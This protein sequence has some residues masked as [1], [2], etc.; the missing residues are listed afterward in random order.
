MKM[1]TWELWDGAT[2]GKGDAENETKA[3]GALHPQDLGTQAEGKG[4]SES[5]SARWTK[6]WGVPWHV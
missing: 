4:Q 3:E 2:I 5:T 1:Q 6:V